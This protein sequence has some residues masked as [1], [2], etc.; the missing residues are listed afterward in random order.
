MGTLQSRPLASLLRLNGMI[1]V[2]PQ[3]K[4]SISVPMGGYLKS[5]SLLPG[6]MVRKGQV[7]ALV[8]D[9]QYIQLQQD[10][11]TAKARISYLKNDYERQ[12]ELNQ[13]KASS[14]KAT[15]LALSEYRTQVVLLRSLEEKLQ[16]AGIRIASLNES[17][18]SRTITVRSPINGFVSKV[19]VNRGKYLL[20]SDVLFEVVNLSDMHLTVRVFEKDLSKIYKG[21]KLWAYTNN[22]PKKRYA[23][24]VSLI[25]KDLSPDRS[26]EVHCHFEQMDA[27]LVPGTYMNADVEVSG[28]DAMLL[29]EAAIVRFE[30]K[31][32]VFVQKS[33]ETYEMTEVATGTQEGG[34]TEIAVPQTLQ[35]KKIVTKGAYTLL[36]ALKN[37]ADE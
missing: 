18:I 14:D 13:S 23:C 9:Q 28:K 36:M 26:A 35:G 4:V 31:E 1:E 6:M 32:Y 22:N 10:Y 15:D 27:Q 11:F 19:N 5:A 33:A 30:G 37:T 8:E 34:W 21:Q 29:P 20:P 17:S 12:R 24:T 7:L 3:N 25:G 16:L 2:P